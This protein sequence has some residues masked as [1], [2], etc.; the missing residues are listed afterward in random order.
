MYMLKNNQSIYDSNAR[1]S[2]SL[3]VNGNE[4]NN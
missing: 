2:R 1:K 4:E 3:Y